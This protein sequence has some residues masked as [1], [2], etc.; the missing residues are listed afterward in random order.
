MADLLLYFKSFSSLYFLPPWS[1]PL[2]RVAFPHP[3][4]LLDICC[5]LAAQELTSLWCLEPFTLYR[6][7]RHRWALA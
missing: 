7:E 5:I 6:G 1:I 2:T 3:A 4:C